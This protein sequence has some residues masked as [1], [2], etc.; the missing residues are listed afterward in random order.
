[1]AIVL[2]NNPRSFILWGGGMCSEYTTK[3]TAT[4]KQLIEDKGAEGSQASITGDDM[5]E[6]L[7]RMQ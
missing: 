5:R 7:A 1:M 3:L 4:L 2:Q 6:A